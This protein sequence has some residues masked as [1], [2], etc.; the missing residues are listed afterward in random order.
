MHED[1]KPEGGGSAAALLPGDLRRIAEVAGLE[2][3]LR[4][5]RAFR[6]TYLYVPG[7]DEFEKQLRDERIRKDY[8][9]GKSVRKLSLQYGVTE[10]AIWKILKKP[11]RPLDPLLSRFLEA[12]EGD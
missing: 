12:D 6:G 5:A 11:H 8:D 7:L 3:A 2:A 1:D 4:I 9:Q 10:R